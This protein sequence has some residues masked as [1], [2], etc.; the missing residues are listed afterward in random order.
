M[1]LVR[2]QKALAD[3]GVASRRKSEELIA[4]GRVKVDGR[5]VVRMGEKVDPEAQRIECDGVLVKPAPK[6][7]Y[8][9]NKPRGAV[10]TT[11]DPQGRRRAV[12][13]IPGAPAGA[14][15]VGRLDAETE[16]LVIVTNDGDFAQRVAHPRFGVG[17]VYLAWAKGAM[18]PSIPRALMKGVVLDGLRCRAKDAGIVRQEETGTLIRIVMGE[19]RKREI[20]RMLKKLNH[21]VV[22]LRRTAIG[23]VED[24]S[25]EPGQW[26]ELRPEEVE[27]L[28]KASRPPKRARP[29]GHHAQGPRTGPPKRGKGRSRPPKNRKPPV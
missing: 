18:N 26:R 7:Y 11:S 24:E 28:L 22:H 13:F 14:Y 10:C 8:L 9:L 4:A 25:L 21:P 19:G 27:A 5:M 12:D 20:R 17:K 3:A 16:G 29:R 6:A 1:A 23:P 2:L 15:T